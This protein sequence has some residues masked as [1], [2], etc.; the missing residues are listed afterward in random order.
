MKKQKISKYLI[1]ISVFTFIT[2]FVLVVEKSYNNLMGPINQAKSGNLT[3]PIN[4]NL[5]FKTLE[6]IEKKEE[7]PVP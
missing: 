3:K 6:E 4:P 1:F 7:L 5:D 2:V